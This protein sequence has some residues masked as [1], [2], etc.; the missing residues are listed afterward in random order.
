MKESEEEAQSNKKQQ[1]RLR[2][3]ACFQTQGRDDLFEG[4]KNQNYLKYR[5]KFS[6]VEA[7]ARQVTF[8]KRDQ[9]F[10][11]QVERSDEICKRYERSLGYHTRGIDCKKFVQYE[12]V[13]TSE[14]YHMIRNKEPHSDFLGD[15]QMKQNRPAVPLFEIVSNDPVPSTKLT[16][17]RIPVTKFSPV[18][19]AKAPHN[20][21]TDQESYQKSSL[22]SSPRSCFS[23]GTNTRAYDFKRNSLD[24]NVPGRKVFLPAP[25]A[26][27]VPYDYSVDRCMKY[28][29][30]KSIDF[31]RLSKKQSAIFSEKPQPLQTTDFADS[32][33]E[34]APTS[35][36]F[37]SMMGRYPDESK[38]EIWLKSLPRK[39]K[40]ASKSCFTYD[41]LD[42][43]V[44][45][46][47]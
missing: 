39:S 14:K 7:Q 4:E 36:S 1:K 30:R 37:K 25:T 44:G 34:K 35:V 8:P 2:V 22:H 10:P 26:Q 31:S 11:L 12:T 20:E 15:S 38:N 43:F 46:K 13:F 19:Y 9:N 41:F 29:Q 3:S 47:E 33:T 6:E 23:S 28:P 21:Y 27:V 42:D 40:N 5:P 17:P 32:S 16:K 45:F 24:V 18:R